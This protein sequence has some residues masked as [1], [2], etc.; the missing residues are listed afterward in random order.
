MASWLHFEETWFGIIERQALHRAGVA[1]VAEFR[2]RIQAFVTGRNDRCHPF[3]STE[4]SGGIGEM[5][6]CS[7]PSKTGYE[8]LLPDAANFPP[9]TIVPLRVSCHRVALTA[10]MGIEKARGTQLLKRIRETPEG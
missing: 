5:A 2:K 4:T 10:A 8:S 6:N 3:V 1:S 9:L 7:T